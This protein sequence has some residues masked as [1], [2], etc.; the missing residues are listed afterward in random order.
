VIAPDAKLR[1]CL[2]AL[3]VAVLEVRVIGWKGMEGGLTE[4]ESEQVADLMDAVHDLPGLI[5]SWE[6]CDEKLLCQ[7]LADVDAKY[8]TGLLA[9]YRETLEH[10]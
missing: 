6:H 7:M 3:Y 2:Q 9:G 8:G 10:G 5:L 4:H 1:A